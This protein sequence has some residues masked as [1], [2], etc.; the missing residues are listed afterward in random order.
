MFE[1]AKLVSYTLYPENLSFGIR[2][3]PQKLIVR[4]FFVIHAARELRLL[5]PSSY[6][7]ATTIKGMHLAA[8]GARVAKKKLKA[9]LL[10]FAYAVTSRVLSQFATGLFWVSTH[11]KIEKSMS[12]TKI[13]T[14][15]TQDWHPFTWL[16]LITGSRL[17]LG[18]ESWGW[19]IEWSPALIG[20]GM[21]VGMN[22]SL[23]FAVGRFIAW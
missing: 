1:E 3:T 19:F 21:L 2:L 7:A 5:F 11:M 23:S 22:V 6:A 15:D 8:D 4:S 18:P 9:L 14:N 20:S 17:F 13:L 10:A 16:Y 12:Q